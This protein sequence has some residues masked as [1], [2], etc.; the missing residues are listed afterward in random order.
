MVVVAH[1][2]PSLLRCII[3]AVRRAGRSTDVRKLGKQR[4][5]V[6]AGLS[7][8]T[9]TGGAASPPP[10]FL[11]GPRGRIVALRFVGLTRAAGRVGGDAL[12]GGGGSGGAPGSAIACLLKARA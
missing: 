10:C 9:S 6:D 2:P 4:F 3:H 12:L 1:T 11:V 8:G 7:D 5:S